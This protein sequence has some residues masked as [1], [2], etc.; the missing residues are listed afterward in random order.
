MAKPKQVRI[1]I[2]ISED[3]YKAVEKLGP[4][5][6]HWSKSHIIERAIVSYCI[7][8]IENGNKEANNEHN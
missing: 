6:Q 8:I 1:T 5:H 7:A 2:T 4:L 3:T